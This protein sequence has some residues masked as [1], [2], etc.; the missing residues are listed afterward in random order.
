MLALVLVLGGL[1]LQSGS[2]AEDPNYPGLPEF[3]DGGG[4]VGPRATGLSHVA[5]A[6]QWV[7]LP[8]LF[9]AAFAP[10]ASNETDNSCRRLGPYNKMNDYRATA[11]LKSSAGA[12]DPWG[13]VGPFLTRTVAFGSIPV[14]VSVAIRQPRDAENLPVGLKIRQVVGFYCPG[15]SPFPTNP[16][17]AGENAHWD[18]ATVDGELGIAIAALKV[19][20]VDLELAGSCRTTTPGTIALRAPEH[21][22]MNPEN[23]LPGVRPSEA[24]MY[25]TPYFGFGEGGLLTGTVDIPAFT[26]CVT[27][28]GEDMSRL[29]TA[30][31]SGAD[32]PVTM[33]SE[34]LEAE[35][36]GATGGER[37]EPLP[38]LPFPAAD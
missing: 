17:L 5:T 3:N 27:R 1:S 13:Q 32:N 34:G 21:W 35:P 2:A 36:C 9:I 6:K 12:P 37:C 28:S 31:V 16:A 24:N 25:T 19:D 18:P 14:E 38:G 15:R 10:F 4:W 7:R 22:T 30:T 8:P 23:L 11:Y 26:G 20:G 33:R 29:L